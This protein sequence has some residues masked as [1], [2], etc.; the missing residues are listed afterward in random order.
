[1]AREE[2]PHAPLADGIGPGGTFSGASVL[3]VSQHGALLGRAGD[4]WQDFGGHRQIGE[5]PHATA[6]REMNEEIG[7]TATHVDLVQDHPIWVVHAG[8]R[9]AVFVATIT[10]ASRARSDWGLG[11]AAT[12][13]LDEY[14]NNFADFANF[15]EANMFGTEMVH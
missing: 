13:E 15:F 14:R 3:V 6:F 12:P 2:T 5:T 1:M 11:T 8:Y 9:H 7:L 4:I 10:E